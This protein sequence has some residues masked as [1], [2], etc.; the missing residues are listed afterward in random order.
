MGGS[1]VPSFEVTIPSGNRPGSRLLIPVRGMQHELTVP[2]GAGPGQTLT[3]MVVPPGAYPG[4][5]VIVLTPAGELAVTI[6]DMSPGEILIVDAGTDLRQWVETPS[7]WE[8]LQ[9]AVPCM[10]DAR[11]LCYI[12]LGVMFFA[13]IASLA[14]PHHYGYG[15]YGYGRG[16][17]Y[18]PQHPDSSAYIQYRVNN[19]R[20]TQGLAP[21][22]PLDPKTA[23][24]YPGKDEGFERGVD[25]AGKEI[26]RY[27]QNN[28][29]YVIPANDYYAWR[30]EHYHGHMSHDILNILLLGS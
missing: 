27:E 6:P 30:A 19:A 28:Q 1:H 20:N 7:C 10:F 15:G 8:R 12:L 23:A 11:C 4:S 24:E 22:A 21:S 3:C 5:E 18:Q 25:K 2:E 13:L 29:V 16:Y 26:Y 17:G 9:D 14:R